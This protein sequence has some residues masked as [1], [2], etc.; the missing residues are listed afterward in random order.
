LFHGFAAA[1]DGALAAAGNDKL[2]TALFT[3]VFFAYLIRHLVKPNYKV[4]AGAMSKPI[5]P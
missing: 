1:V 4:L 3:A 5:P 2:G